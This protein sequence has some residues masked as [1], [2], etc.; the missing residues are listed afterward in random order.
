M[1]FKYIGHLVHIFS[2]RENVNLHDETTVRWSTKSIVIFK[3]NAHVISLYSK[4]GWLRTVLWDYIYPWYVSPLFPSFC[5]ESSNSLLYIVGPVDNGGLS[6]YTAPFIKRKDP[7]YCEK[8]PMNGVFVV[9]I[10]TTSYSIFESTFDHSYSWIFSLSRRL[11]RVISISFRTNYYRAQWISN[12]VEDRRES[13]YNLNV[14]GNFFAYLNGLICRNV[15]SEIK[16]RVILLN[17]NRV[18]NRSNYT[19][20]IFSPFLYITNVKDFIFNTYLLHGDFINFFLKREF[21]FIKFHFANKKMFFRITRVIDYYL[22]F[23]HVPYFSKKMIKTIHRDKYNPNFY[24][25]NILI[26]SPLIFF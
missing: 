8:K 5:V 6:S 16:Y 21:H 22:L 26:Q 9:L 15:S 19:R 11:F 13:I 10:Y 17:R 1:I 14:D 25:K 3:Q 2:S 18:G 24:L 23:L 7:L 4:E 12:G 20:W